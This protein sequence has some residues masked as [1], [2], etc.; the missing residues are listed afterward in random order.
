MGTLPG[1]ERLRNKTLPIPPR[2]VG[3]KTAGAPMKAKKALKRLNKIESSLAA[4]IEQYSPGK[5]QFHELLASAKT[6][7]AQAKA[8]V[9]PDGVARKPPVKAKSAKRRGITTEGRKRLS[10]AAKRR[11][12]A[13][14]RKGISAV[15][16]R[17]LRRTA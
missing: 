4:V 5:P 10:L 12:A 17:P 14:K 16:G 11:W 15:T 6:C 9:N 2:M 13:A 7:V 3:W 1:E 8:A